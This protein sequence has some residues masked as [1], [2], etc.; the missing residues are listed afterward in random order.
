[1]GMTKEEMG[2][3]NS[4]FYTLFSRRQSGD[5]GESGAQPYTAQ[6][7]FKWT[8]IVYSDTALTFTK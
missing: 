2:M 1:M 7:L 3:T 4:R 5:R 8:W 6:T